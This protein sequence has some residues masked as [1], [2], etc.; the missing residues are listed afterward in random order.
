MDPSLYP[1]PSKFNGHRYLALSQEPDE[2][3]KH[4]YVTLNQKHIGFGHGSHAC[5]GRFFASNEL[6]TLLVHLL[7]KYDWEFEDGKR[8]ANVKHGLTM[9]PDSEAVVLSRSRKSEIEL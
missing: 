4:Q 7:I 3:N 1:D 2:E 5:P 8:P 9:T 6:K